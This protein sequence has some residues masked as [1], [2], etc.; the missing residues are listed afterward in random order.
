[1]AAGRRSANT[2]LGYS[3][4]MK[5]QV[6]L[7]GFMGT[8]KTRVSRPLAAALGWQRI[9]LDELI[10]KEA[11]ESIREIF[12]KG[13][14]G[15]FRVIEC[16]VVERVAQMKDIVVATGGG[17]VLAAANRDAMR[18]RGFVACLDASAATI[19]ERVTASGARISER[20]LLSGDDPLAA[21]SRLKEERAPFYAEADVTIVTDGLTP[22]EVTHQILLA[23]RKQPAVP[24]G[25]S[26]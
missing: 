21:I 5:D 4:G 8:G 6:W 3:S 14:E 12:R 16:Q 25:P 1:M 13:G 19:A 11:G 2:A 24:G 15:A 18:A 9:D 7:T 17:A 26:S 23:L 10:E 22:D 20:P